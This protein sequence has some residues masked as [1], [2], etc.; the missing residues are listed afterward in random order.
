MDNQEFAIAFSEKN[1]EEAIKE[2]SLKIK[3]VFPKQIKYL[4]IL[5]THHYQPSSIQQTINLTLKPNQILGIQV[6]FVIYEDKIAEKGIAVFCINKRGVTLKE[7]FL[8]SGDAEE[9]ES[10]LHSSL[11]KLNRNEFYLLSF[12]SSNFKPFSYLHGTR[13]AMGNY[14]NLLGG[15]YI[16]PFANRELKFS[17]AYVNEGMMN[18]AIGGVEINSFKLGGYY[19]LGKPFTVTKISHHRSVVEEID[20]RPAVNI[21]RKY[22]EEKF[23]AFKKNNLFSFYPLGIK[24]DG[25]Y[26]LVNIRE[27]LEDGSLIAMGELKEGS[28]GYIMLLDPNLLFESIEERLAPLK[29]HKSGLVFIA[30]TL[31]RHKILMD[32]SKEEIRLIKENL[33]ENFKIIGAY[34]DYFIFSNK[35]KLNLEIDSADMLL[36]LWQ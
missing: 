18:T 13:M 19:P 15:G 11:G 36:S 32:K 25:S 1:A 27:S 12:I 31:G 20:G 4:L 6:P 21:Y 30:N 24:E 10:H 33:G 8:K 23:P 34:F 7:S 3:L 2:V 35:Q 17:N 14:I 22:L 16:T 9:I 29:K 28:R 5:F 26:R